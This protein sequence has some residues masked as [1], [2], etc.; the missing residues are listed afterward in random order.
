MDSEDRSEMVFAGGS[1]DIAV[2]KSGVEVWGMGRAWG[3]K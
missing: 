2:T 3:E 1:S